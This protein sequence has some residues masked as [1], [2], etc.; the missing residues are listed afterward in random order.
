MQDDISQLL[1]ELPAEQKQLLISAKRMNKQVM[2]SKF[3]NQVIKAGNLPLP[4]VG[5][6][7]HKFLYL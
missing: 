7:Q 1:N 4:I 6:I 3:A 5:K 2:K